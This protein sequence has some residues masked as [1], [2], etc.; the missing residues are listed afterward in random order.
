MTKPLTKLEVAE[1]HILTAVQMVTL[2]QS[3]VSVHVVVKSAE[4]ILLSLG[5]TAAIKLPMDFLSYIR[6]AH[7]K[8]VQAKMKEA[9]NF[10]KHADRDPRATLSAE[11]LVKLPELNDM[12]LMASIEH[13]RSLAKGIE[14]YMSLYLVVVMAIYP[15]LAA[16]LPQDAPSLVRESWA[17]L[18]GTKRREALS[19]LRSWLRQQKLLM[20]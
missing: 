6:P 13:Y 18:K 8:H 3:P 7:R 16:D 19:M 20:A 1:R 17:V 5:K 4:E 15:G 9:Y 10:F 11:R 12:V 14:P 2:E